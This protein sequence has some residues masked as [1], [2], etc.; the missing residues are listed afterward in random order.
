MASIDV[1]MKLEGGPALMRALRRQEKAFLA[2]FGAALPA[3]AEA[4][5][6]SANAAAPQASGTLV[7]SAVVTSVIQKS[8]GRVRAVAAYTDEKAAAVHEGIHWMQ[9]VVGTKGFKW[10]ER[11]L[12][13]FEADFVARIGA[14]LRRIAGGGK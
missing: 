7:S 11:S 12:H 10:F 2:E 3:E 4:L 1:L 14:R 13:A 9:Q 6:Q 8:K 5:M